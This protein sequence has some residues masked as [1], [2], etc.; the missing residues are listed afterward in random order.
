[1]TRG[2]IAILA[3][4]SLAA[5]APPAYQGGARP[6]SR[7]QLDADPA[8]TTVGSLPP[9]PQRADSDCGPAVTASVLAYWGVRTSVRQIDRALRT[10]GESGVRAG[11][12]R[13]HLRGRGM[14]AFLVQGTIDDLAY[15]VA[16]GRPVIIGTLKRYG[17]KTGLRHYQVVV[18]VRAG[19]THFATY[20]PAV[21]WRSYTREHLLDEWSPTG[22]LAL[23]VL[24]PTN[25]GRG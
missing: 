10:P 18:G 7:A 17:D 24:P 5:C 6:L 14:R 16:R 3:A 20:D 8:W 2:R 21:G 19:G 12:L 25:R 23:V 4:L 22:H 13:D 15:E 1:M 9:R 11:D